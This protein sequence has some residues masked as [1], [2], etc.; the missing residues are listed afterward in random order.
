MRLFW[1]APTRAGWLYYYPN[2]LADF[3]VKRGNLPRRFI[4]YTPAA[5]GV[6][7]IGCSGPQGPAAALAAAAVLFVVELCNFSRERATLTTN[8]TI[9]DPR[10]SQRT[11]L[12]PATH[13]V[14]GPSVLPTLSITL[15]GPFV[16][17]HPRY[18][19]GDLVQG[20]TFAITV[21]V[22]NHTIVRCQRPISVHCAAPQSLNVHMDVPPGALE[23]QLPALQSGEV[24]VA[25]VRL[26]AA[27]ESRS[28]VIRL[29]VSHGGSQVALEV[30]VRCIRPAAG[31][32]FV[33]ATVARYPGGCRS[34]FAWRGDMDWYDEVTFQ[35]I[36]GLERTLG[37]AARYCFPQTLFLSSRLSLCPEETSAYFAHYALDRGQAEVP[38]FIDWMRNNVEIRQRFGYPFRFEKPL[39]LELGNHMHLHYGTDAAASPDNQWKF[40]AGIC[41]GTY[42]WSP[43]E[44]GSYEE[45]RA[46]AME[47]RRHFETCFGYTPRSWAMPDSTRDARTPAAVE[48]AGCAV[49]S[50]S[51]ATHAA[52]V[53][54]Q[55][56]PHHPAET[57]AVELTKRY[58][59]DPQS[60]RHLDMIRFWVHRAHR[61]GIPVVFMCHQHMRQYEGYACERFT[62]AVLRDVLTDF[63]GDLFISTVS[64]IGI[65]WRDFFSPKDRRVAV[66]VED[67][68]VHVANGSEYAHEAAPVDV[69][70]A[71]GG[72]ATYLMDLPAGAE[73]SLQPCAGKDRST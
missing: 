57:N 19:L 53:L 69:V 30:D 65:Y 33:S 45:Q 46:N 20:R 36:E 8:Y 1:L 39:A 73:V 43:K 44:A 26:E 41:T 5:A 23:V 15:R 18:D 49:L 70:F 3:L 42:S 28:G 14:P 72:R 17:R 10:H 9:A 51:D 35:S 4:E 55:P 22:A 24:A 62:E 54:F 60:Q 56:P 61:L 29:T 47:C 31:A 40:E 2:V 59:G 12:S 68:V 7:A 25:T 21:V 67:G 38:A 6:W 58:P 11:L 64:G 13:E 37:L 63:N 71:D 48:D 32:G 27:T 66:R 16:S 50:D 34:A 52:N